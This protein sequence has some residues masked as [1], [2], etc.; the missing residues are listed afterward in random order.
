LKL[1]AIITINNIDK[2]DTKTSRVLDEIFGL[3]VVFGEKEMKLKFI[4]FV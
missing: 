1:N 3:L 4:I 2:P